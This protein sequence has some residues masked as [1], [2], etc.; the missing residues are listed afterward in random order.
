[1]VKFVY[2]A[3]RTRVDI[4]INNFLAIINTHLLRCYSNIDPRLPQLVH[5][6]KHWAKRRGVNDAYRQ[7][8]SLGR[9]T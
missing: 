5:L 6:V 4:T 8:Q 9:A 3:T 1:V 7:V 2:P